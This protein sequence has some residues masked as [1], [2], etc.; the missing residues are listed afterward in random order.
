MSA[1]LDGIGS[2]QLIAGTLAAALVGVFAVT[3]MLKIV[4]ER[5][6]RGFA[7]YVFILG[8]LVLID[9]FGTHFFF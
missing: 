9:Q 1:A 8:A 5:S 4:R 7:I 2:A 6:L 3:L